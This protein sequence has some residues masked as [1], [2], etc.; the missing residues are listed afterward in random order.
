V[1]ISRSGTAF[2]AEGRICAPTDARLDYRGRV[3][4]GGVRQQGFDGV[5]RAALCDLLERLG[6][7]APTVLGPWT[8]RDIAVHLYLREHDAV[9]GPGLVLPGPWARVAARHHG[10]ALGRDFSQLVAAVRSGPR[11][12]FRFGWLRRVPNLNEMFVHHEDVR[13]AN[14]GAPRVFEPA[15]EQAL[16]ANVKGGAWL[17]CRRLHV[18]GLELHNAS[19]QESLRARRG[20]DPVRV[21]GEPGELLLYVFGRQKVA[22]VDLDGPPNSLDVLRGTHLGL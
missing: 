6:P 22:H 18:C 7:D 15:M 10:Q 2:A 1:A 14:G 20:K 13:R 17:L 19:I 8:T 4:G 21:T 9:A 11:G 5:E 16:W 3:Y 12:V